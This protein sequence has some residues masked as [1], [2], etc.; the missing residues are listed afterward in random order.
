MTTGQSGRTSSVAIVGAGL[1]GT[2]LSIVMARRNFQVDV[3]ER[4]PDPRKLDRS[5]GR[6]INLTLCTRGLAALDVAGISDAVRASAVRVGG[7][8]LHRQDRPLTWLPYGP[9]NESLFAISRKHL[10]GVL[11]DEAEK[12]PGIH[13]HF[14]HRCTGL[15]L[16]Q[17]CLELTNTTTDQR[18]SRNHTF[19]IGADGAFSAVR[20]SVQQRYNFNYSQEYSSSSYSELPIVP[21]RDDDWTNRTD[22]LHLWPRG[23]SM[24][25]AIPNRD[26]TFTGTLLLPSRGRDSRE[27][28]KTGTA[29]LA[30]MRECFPDAV[31]HVPHLTD[32]Y[33]SARPI[34]MVTIRCTPWSYRGRVLLVGDAAHAVFPS[35]G[36]GANAGFED[37]IMLDECL[38]RWDENWDAICHLFEERRRPQTDAI[39]ALSK[40]H[41]DDLQ[42][43][44]NHD[45]FILRSRVE[46]RLTEL[47]PG[48]YRSLYGMV[49]FT[50]MPYTEA[51]E[52]D[53]GRRGLID[54][55]VSLPVI[56]DEL[57]NSETARV[58][59][60][61]VRRHGIE[62]KQV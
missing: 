55:L 49:A 62:V 58:I 3:Y 17:N 45:D 41:L 42:E 20:L 48:A 61:V 54:E 26:G 22:A 31:D 51:L 33:F 18:V 40:Q 23:R 32:T 36:Q 1:V 43:T 29:L 6:S 50:C 28:I 56:R 16:E 52:L 8:M 30:F 47:F 4:L 35:Y 60:D 57:N 25:L 21:N 34:P 2:F 12:F 39:A 10:S 27:T 38:E 53:A 13:F 15:D 9:K 59:T 5:T 7:R 44:M 11:L 14:S 37:C 24:L 19:I 46:T